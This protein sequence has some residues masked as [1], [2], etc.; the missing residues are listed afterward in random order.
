MQSG[1]LLVGEHVSKVHAA[2]GQAL[3]DGRAIDDLYVEGEQFGDHRIGQEQLVGI[4]DGWGQY[5]DG[6]VHPESIGLA[7]LLEFSCRLSIGMVTVGCDGLRVEILVGVHV[8]V[9]VV[10][11]LL[12]MLAVLRLAVLEFGLQSVPQLDILLTAPLEELEIVLNCLPLFD[13]GF[14]GGILLSKLRQQ[15]RQ[16]LPSPRDEVGGDDLDDDAR[17]DQQRR[18]PTE[19]LRHRF[20]L[21]L[22]EV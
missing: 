7:E 17:Y 11:Q 12:Q 13:E 22:R 14:A 16:L 10:S 8:L 6:C 15:L 1:I 2:F 18:Q 19:K 4:A 9:G 5:G 3:I 20:A 21:Q